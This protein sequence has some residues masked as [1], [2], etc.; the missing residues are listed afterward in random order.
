[1]PHKTWLDWRAIKLG[2][3]NS[4]GLAMEFNMYNSN[5]NTVYPI[6]KFWFFFLF[7]KMT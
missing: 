6:N 4:S 2:V 1:M 5:N 7:L 3:V